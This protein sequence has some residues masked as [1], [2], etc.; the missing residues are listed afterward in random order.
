MFSRSWHSWLLHP[1]SG[2]SLQARLNKK[3]PLHQPV[4]PEKLLQSFLGPSHQLRLC[5]Q[6]G[7]PQSLWFTTSCFLQHVHSWIHAASPRGTKNL[8][9]QRWH[10]WTSRRYMSWLSKKR[11]L[12]SLS[13]RNASW[14][15]KL[16]H[17]IFP[18]VVNEFLLFSCQLFIH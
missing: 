7:S 3:N 16:F 14:H 10:V 8:R 1:G 11:P 5:C 4:T 12:L 18:P 15:V 13:R 17:V 6:A 2:P 9:E